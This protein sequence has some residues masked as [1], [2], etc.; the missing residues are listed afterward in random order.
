MITTNVLGSGRR[1]HA[2]KMRQKTAAQIE[3]RTRR[4]CFRVSADRSW[5]KADV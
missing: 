1:E 5:A 3:A 4:V 2:G